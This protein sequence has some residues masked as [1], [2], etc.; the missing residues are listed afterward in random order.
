MA[1]R[2]TSQFTD[3]TDPIYFPTFIWDVGFVDW[4]AGNYRLATGSPYKGI[5]T[6]NKNIGVDTVA[7]NAATGFPEAPTNL[8]AFSKNEPT[9]KLTWVDNSCNETG[10]S[11]ER[12]ESDGMGF[13][14]ATTGPNT[15]TWLLT[16]KC[17]SPITFRVR[18]F[19]AF[20]YYRGQV[21]TYAAGDKLR[22][23]IV[24][25][26]VKYYKN[27]A[28]LYTSAVQPMY[29]LRMDTSLSTSWENVT[30]AYISG[31]LMP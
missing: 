8:L 20:G 5:A 2:L 4:G 17:V 15:T 26:V 23:A 9:P 28:L 24:G 21:G 6:D 1:A 22:V 31:V 27:G 30:N 11:I 10:F 25:G 13:Q 18:A 29:P 3:N 7:L 16:V 14:V 12:L 19:N